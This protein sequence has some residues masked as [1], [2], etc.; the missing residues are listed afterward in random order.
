MPTTSDRSGRR[1]PSSQ[2]PPSEAGPKAASAS[3]EINDRATSSSISGVIPIASGLTT[4]MGSV[5]VACA[6]ASTAAIR[7]P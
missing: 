7:S 1:R 3:P 5:A 4:S 2:N 6:S